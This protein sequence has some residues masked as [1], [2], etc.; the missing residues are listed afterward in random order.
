[1]SNDK[2]EVAVKKSGGERKG[3]M[4]RYTA[5]FEQMER[6]FE[7]FFQRRFFAP[8]W[9]PRLKLPE[10]ADVSASVDMFEEGDDL[11]I[12]AE[13]PGM[14]KD[15]ISIDF[16]DDVVTISGE[17]KTEERTERKDYYCVERS[18]GSFSRKLQLPVDIQ[19]DK[20]RA[21]FK[22]GVLEIRMP[23]SEE[24]KQ[25]VRKITVD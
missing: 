14:K 13:I 18:F 24:A 23:K 9:M 1:M 15:E 7:D 8:S 17:K 16:A 5:P 20:T 6:M 3:E 2:Q 4:Q 21:S 11:V 22:D 12:K 19:I 10:F 25:K